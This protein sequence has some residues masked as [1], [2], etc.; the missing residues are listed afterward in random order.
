MAE[1]PWPA[2]LAGYRVHLVGIKGTGMTALAEVL[3]CRGAAVSGSD[4]P[5]KFYTDALLDRLGVPYRE[6]FAAAN[7]GPEVQLV[8][9]SPAYSRDEHVELREARSR[10]IPIL[11][12]PEALGRLSEEA[13]STGVAGTHGKTTTTA[14]AGT[15]LDALGLPVTVLAGSEVPGFGGRSTLIR[16]ERY[17]VAETCEYRRNFLNFRPRRLVITS[18]EADHLDYYRDLH[19]VLDAF[20]SYAGLLPIGG[21]LIYAADDP[22][23]RAVTERIYSGRGDLRLVP[24]GEGA[25]G[26]YRLQEVASRE[27]LTRFR[28]RGFPG[29]F[30]LRVP[31]RHMAWNAAAAVALAGDLLAVEGRSLAGPALEL[32]R[33][34]LAGF[35]GVRRRSEVIGEAGGVLFLDDYGHHP[36]EIRTT[37]EGFRS[38]YPGRRLVV[39][40]MPHTYSR[41]RALLPEFASCF[42]AAHEVI[43]HRIYASAREQAGG[44]VDGRT[45]FREVAARHPAVRYFEEPLE[46]VDALAAELKA[47]DLF[48]TMGAGD[49]WKVGQ[50]LYSRLGGSP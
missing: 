23:A 17:L 30:V 1:N 8:I 38:F 33:Q 18:V 24:Y 28:I 13:D 11:S 9:H 37:L 6:A 42:A 2:S 49:N 35:Q 46:A 12:Y 7:V 44:G 10:G 22:G 3:V 4:G 45:L 36:T 25:Q 32:V 31:G 29:E 27:G 40:F 16:G 41:T 34:A 26:E 48:V 50:A 14:L 15:L 5:E 47:G 20:V 39:D 19:D 43:L 21:T